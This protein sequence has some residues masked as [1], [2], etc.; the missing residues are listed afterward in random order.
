MLFSSTPASA[1][2]TVPTAA[3]KAIR[4]KN[5]LKGLIFITNPSFFNEY[6]L[7]EIFIQAHLIQQEL[8][9]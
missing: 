7:Y 9:I 4:N 5:I 6:K 2:F 1:P 3:I 8:H